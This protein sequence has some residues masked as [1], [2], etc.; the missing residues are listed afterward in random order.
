M[1]ER[2]KNYMYTS[3]RKMIHGKGFMD[4]LKGI[5]SY[6]FQNKDLIAKPMLSAVGNVGA[7]ALTEGTKALFK[8][9]ASNNN[10]NK[11]MVTNTNTNTNASNLTPE[12]IGI[13]NR[14]SNPVG[15][16]IVSGIKIFKQN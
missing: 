6:I 8:K 2:K 15:N 12:S 3:N 10:N 14:L 4:T 13:L 16:I 7:L 5:G 9:L 1:I 11:H